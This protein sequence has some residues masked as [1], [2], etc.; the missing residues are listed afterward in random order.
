MAAVLAA[1][2]QLRASSLSPSQIQLPEVSAGLSGTGFEYVIDVLLI[3]PNFALSSAN[4]IRTDDAR[5]REL[6]LK[7]GNDQGKKTL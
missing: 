2:Q 4:C 7:R 3:V 6:R 1:G 5:L